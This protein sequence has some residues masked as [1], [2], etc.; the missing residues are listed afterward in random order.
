MALRLTPLI[1]LTAALIAGP[2]QAWAQTPSQAQAAAIRSSCR[3]DYMR[4]CSNVPPGGMASLQCLREHMSGLSPDCASAVSAV[5][6]ATPAPPD[7]V[8]AARTPMMMS[9]RQELRLLRRACGPDYRALCQDAPPG[10]G[11]AIGCL[12]DHAADLSPTCQNALRSGR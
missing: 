1:C 7:Q 11:R 5:T 10:G 4:D 12:R 8:A 6:P 2:V 9:P 3:S